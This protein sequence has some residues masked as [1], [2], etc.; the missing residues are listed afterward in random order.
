MIKVKFSG[1]ERDSVMVISINLSLHYGPLGHRHDQRVQLISYAETT[2]HM[3][4]SMPILPRD[5]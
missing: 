4:R 1:G 3:R 5:T 2:P